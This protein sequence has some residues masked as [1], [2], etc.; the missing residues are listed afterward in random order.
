MKVAYRS[1][2]VNKDGLLLGYWQ[3]QPWKEG[4]NEASC[5]EGTT[6][7]VPSEY[8][9]CGFYAYKEP[10]IYDFNYAYKVIIAG[11]VLMWGN[12]VEHRVGFRSQ[13][14]KIEALFSPDHLGNLD[15]PCRINRDQ[16][17]GID[18]EYPPTI[19]LKEVLEKIQVNY[20]LT[21]QPA[22]KLAYVKYNGDSFGEEKEEANGIY[23]G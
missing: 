1:W 13:K 10:T 12:I 21:F 9:E 23:K 18:K 6:H 16:V 15:V 11:A 5:F 2:K 20:G 19:I 7:L 22:P 17:I 3:H 14:A 4:E 8:C